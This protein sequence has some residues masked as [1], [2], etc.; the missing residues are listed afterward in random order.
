MTPDDIRERIWTAM[1]RIC[2]MDVTMND[3]ADAAAKEAEAMLDEAARVE[4]TIAVPRDLIAAACSAIDKKRDA[5]N[6]LAQLR[7]TAL[8]Y[9]RA[10]PADDLRAAAL[11]REVLECQEQHY[12]DGARLHMAMIPLAARIRAALAQKGDA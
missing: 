10:A 3:Y 5:P 9:R 1:D 11:L 8:A 4:D 7:K 2:D 6:V 12:G